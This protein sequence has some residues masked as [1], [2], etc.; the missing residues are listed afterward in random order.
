LGTQ[1]RN[2]L[3]AIAVIVVSLAFATAAQAD[4]CTTLTVKTP[5]KHWVW[6]KETREVHGHRVVVRRHG[7]IVYVRVR[8]SYVKV[9]HRQVC[10]ATPPAAL[11][12]TTRLTVS[13]PEHC[14]YVAFGPRCSSW[15]IQTSASSQDGQPL[16]V[17]YPP[18]FSGAPRVELLVG[19]SGGTT[20]LEETYWDWEELG[21]TSGLKIEWTKSGLLPSEVK[22]FELLDPECV[23][24]EPANWNAAGQVIAW[25]WVTGLRERVRSPGGIPDENCGVVISA[26]YPGFTARY[27]PSESERIV[28]ELP[29]EGS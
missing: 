11:P 28:L 26:R 16:G 3:G 25:R 4:T 9:T 17:N 13:A 19:W 7:K 20:R 21:N 1:S 24:S 10:T 23:V 2:V 15:T 22:K 14:T 29:P 5:A 6:V 27:L 8:R 18:M 12:S